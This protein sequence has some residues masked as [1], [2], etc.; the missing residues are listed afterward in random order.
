MDPTNGGGDLLRLGRFPDK[1]DGGNASPV[2]QHNSPC[3]VRD[4]DSEPGRGCKELVNR[5]AVPGGFNLKDR[6]GNGGDELA[7][8]RDGCA[9][10]HLPPDFEPV[11]GVEG[12]AV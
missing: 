6:R 1:G 3:A 2:V 12:A 5:A 8:V 10:L 9:E 4:G 11:E 7:G